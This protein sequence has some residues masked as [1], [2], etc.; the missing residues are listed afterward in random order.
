MEKYELRGL[1]AS[2]LGTVCKII[3]AIGIRQFKGCFKVEDLKNP[4]NIEQVGL[5]VVIDLAG[6]VIANFEKA[7]VDIQAFLASLTG[8]TVDEIRNLSLADYGEMIIEVVTKEEFKDFFG[9]V[10]KLL[11]R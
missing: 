1:V 7:E 11:N 3:T 9:R 8:A 4:D 2:D 10:M 6:I 5:D